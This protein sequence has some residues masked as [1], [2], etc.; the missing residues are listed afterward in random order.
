VFR[1]ICVP[2]DK[3]KKRLDRTANEVL[4]D[5]HFAPNIT[6]LTKSDSVGCVWHMACVGQV[7]NVHRVLFGKPEENKQL[8]RPIHRW[9]NNIKM[10]FKQVGRE[11]PGFIWFR[12]R[13]SGQLI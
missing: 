11:W 9:E 5:L 8:G 2:R 12:T 10:Y 7:R 13:T 1:K 6:W 4:R 3:V